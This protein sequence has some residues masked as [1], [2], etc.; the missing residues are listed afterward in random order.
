MAAPILRP[1]GF[2]NDQAHT[3]TVAL[4]VAKIIQN[5][6]GNKDPLHNSMAHIMEDPER[7]GAVVLK[8]LNLLEQYVTVSG[9]MPQRMQVLVDFLI[10]Q[11][12]R[13]KEG[14]ITTRKIT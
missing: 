7:C 11:G 1:S 2:S 14:S 6:L 12:Q 5:T 4:L 10:V 8:L 3:D 9:Q 13:A